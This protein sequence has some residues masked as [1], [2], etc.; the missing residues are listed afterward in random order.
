M[1]NYERLF[2]DKRKL[3]E[4]LNQCPEIY[5]RADGY[6]CTQICPRANSGCQECT[7]ETDN[8]DIILMWLEAECKE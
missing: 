7:D 6:F 4:A 3:A 5:M 8:V 1:T 2:S